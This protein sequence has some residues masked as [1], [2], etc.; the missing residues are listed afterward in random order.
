MKKFGFAEWAVLFSVVLVIASLWV[1]LHQFKQKAEASRL[2]PYTLIPSDAWLVLDLRQPAE[3]KSFIESDSLFWT[4]FNDTDEI[5][6]IKRAFGQIDSLFLTDTK[7][8]QAFEGS[9]VLVTLHK[10]TNG[11]SQALI[12]FRHGQVTKPGQFQQF[13]IRLLRNNQDYTEY[14]Y[15]GVPIYRYSTTQTKKHYWLSYF[16]GSLLISQSQRHI[17]YAITQH[18]ANSSLG[19]SQS[20]SRLRQGKDRNANN[21]Y[22]NGAHLCEIYKLVTTLNVPALFPCHAF[23]EW[24]AWNFIFHSQE[25]RLTGLAITAASR[26][27]FTGL[28][29]EQ[30]GTEPFLLHFVPSATAAFAM[31]NINPADGFYEALK[32]FLNTDHARIT[33]SCFAN[34]DPMKHLGR[35]MAELMLYNP[36]HT[37]GESVVVL[38]HINDSQGLM[39]KMKSTTSGISEK[40]L[41]NVTDTVF[42]RII[43]HFDSKNWLTPLTKGL[44]PYSLPYFAIIDSVLVAAYN[45]QI[46]SRVLLHHYYGQVIALEAGLAHDFIFQQPESNLLYL[47]NM[48]YLTETIQSSITRPLLR[49]LTRLN[50]GT[51]LTDRLTAQFLAHMPG[52]MFSNVSIH[53]HGSKVATLQKPIWQVS[54]DTAAAIAPTGVFNH[55][56]RSREIIIQDKNNNLYLIDRSGKIL[57]KTQTGSAIISPVF[58]VDRFRNGRYQYLFS[59]LNHLHLID[60]NGNHVRGYPLRLPSPAKHGIT[61]TDYDGNKNY[62]ILFTGENNHIYNLLIDGSQV[63]GWQFPRPLH[64]VSGPIQHFRLKNRDFLVVVDT[65]G[66]PYFFDRRGQPIFET[67]PGVKLQVNTPVFGFESKT[68]VVFAA[69][70]QLG[71]IVE[72]SPQGA[73]RS[74]KPD[75]ANTSKGLVVIQDPNLPHNIIYLLIGHQTI[76]AID[77]FGKLLF[78]K[79]MPGPLELKGAEIRAA[80]KNFAALV[81]HSPNLLYLLNSQG[82]IVAPFPVAGD[83][84]FLIEDWHKDQV[85]VAICVENKQIKAFLVS[86]I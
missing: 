56:D 4:E 44:I 74:I 1:I 50:H 13:L 26:A 65:E 67:D 17:E 51:Y 37:P 34:K 33:D 70:G 60:R 80:N 39:E 40:S 29:S 61:I 35:A 59:T 21:I 6:W 46:V 38:V 11:Q 36:G 42:E 75:T 81:S 3:I 12:Q 66:K 18:H 55:N 8:G 41:L 47:L 84:M 25:L 16:M 24:V 27:D 79:T 30:P 43:W 58:Q 68:E 22:I 63:S 54:L 85:W 53:R 69:L 14:R 9:R 19:A 73:V 82:Q 20:L 15:M 83:Q 78:D 86:G 23:S 10:S 64:P 31:L 7:A 48:P 62:R 45:P 77:R 2:D 72:I 28:L 76:N 52:I 49:I 71:D 5:K 57:W 32:A